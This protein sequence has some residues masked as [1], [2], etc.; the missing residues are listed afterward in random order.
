ML[1]RQLA[2][3]AQLFPIWALPRTC[4]RSRASSCKVQGRRS[5]RT[6]RHKPRGVQ[7]LQRWHLAAGL[8]EPSIKADV[9]KMQ[10]IGNYV[11][12]IN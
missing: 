11:I 4:W 1:G 12:A 10:L 2:A 6:G 8:Q 9:E 3:A 5:W 7:R